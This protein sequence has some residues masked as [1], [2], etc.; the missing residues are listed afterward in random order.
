MASQTLTPARTDEPDGT[1]SPLTSGLVDLDGR[2]FYRIA[3]YDEMPPFFMTL[4][5]ASDLWLFI[6]STGGVTA[7]REEADRALFPYATDDKVSA[8]AGRTG[9]LT[10]LR[11]GTPD[12]VRFWQPFA[13]RRPGDP[14]VERHLYKDHLGTTLVFEETRPDVGLRIRVTWRTSARYGIVREV[15]LA[16]ATDR[17]VD[18]DVLDGF[19]D[20]LPPGVTVQTQS[21]FSRLLDAYKRAEVDAA[22]G[23]GLVYL[24]S[25]LTDKSD[26]S[27][28]LAATVA[29]QVGLDDVEHLLSARQVGAFAAGRPITPEDEVR[30]EK[31]AYLVRTRV[32]LAP[33]E[34]RRWSV[35]ADV[36]Q[37]AAD[38]VRLQ[39]ELA[40]RTAAAAALAA[41]VETT[42]TELD[43]LVGTADAAQ[44]TGDEL[45]AAHHRA[46]VLF[47]V[48]RGGVLVDGY[49][50]H[51]DDL[52]AFVAQ[53]SPRTAARQADWLAALPATDLLDAL[54]ERADATGDPDLL[55]LVREYLPLTFS[56]RHGDPSRPWN[57][58]KIALT[59][60]QGRTRVDFQGNWRD[61]FQN[62]EA[63]AWSFPEY[64]ESMVA[65][66]LDATTADGY[67]PYR[68]SRSGID[69]EV[70]EPSNPWANIGYWSDH[71]IIYLVKLLEASR[72]FHPGRLDALVDRPLFTHADVPYRIASYEQ[73]LVEPIDTIAFDTDA[74]ERVL[75]RVETEG[76]DGRLVHGADGDLVRVSLGEK[77]LLLLL[78][79]TVN[80][81]PDGGIWMNTQRP[82]W[83]DANNA[84]V[85]K[86]LSVVT[87]A[88]LRRGLALARELL[89]DDLTVTAELADLLADV[90]EALRAHAA[91]VEDGFDDTSRRAVM[92]ALG[93]AGTAYRTRVYAGFGGARTTVALADVQ[94]FLDLAQRYVD[95]A[96]HANRRPDGLF[97]A[98]NLLDLRD[99]RA[100]IGRLQEMLEGQVAVLSS[101]VLTP[102]EALDLV[103]ALRRSALYREDQ[104]S[105]QLYP[106]RELPTFLQRNRITAEQVATAP[107]VEALVAAGD[108]SLVLRDVRGE[109]RF[110]PGLHNARDV[111]AALDALPGRVPG[112]SADDLAAGR[113]GVLDV[114]EQVFRHAEFTGR[115]GSF[116]AYEGLGSIYWHMVSKLLLAVQENHERAVVEGADPAV[117]QG[118]ADAYEDVRLGLGYC[119]TPEVYGAFPVDPYSHTPAGR[120]ARQPGMTG[121]V[122]EEVLTRL[123]ELGLRVEDGRVLVRPV[124]LR[125]EEW[126]TAP[127]TFTYRD[128]AQ[129]EQSLPLDAGQLAFTFC[130]V[131]VVYRRGSAVR[132][133][134]HLADGSQVEGA[135]GVLDAAVSEQVFRRTGDVVRIDVEVPAR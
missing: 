101:G 24:N 77:L 99:G 100:R 107:L 13:D 51:T 3:S 11:V 69:W 89:A 41:D 76:A 37:S 94:G 73:T 15:E 39:T 66:F 20:L 55:R 67:N 104:H 29:W 95:A 35:V 28:S 131:P 111:E 21:E 34:V 135:D 27:E 14:D 128:V 22:T 121:Q 82:E 18:A 127:A 70:P 12:G 61:I 118:L 96:L 81:V 88:Y 108:T 48:M 115:S 26:P 7:G 87:L 58:F 116:F 56:R 83:N 126:T 1:S 45:A 46:N 79:K 91:R 9:G 10:L 72:R 62:W 120:G 125:Q 6:S 30:G 4:V 92:D 33:G 43:R 124:L 123:G 40:D 71:Q 38:V 93:A 44:L 16:S 112:L 113:Q 17:A 49:T 63:L 132:V 64:V 109:H 5:G 97:H 110:A 134:A 42:R 52:R 117:V 25:T 32:T 68:I 86:G 57:K 133:V 102:G 98:Y 23:L 85:G 53:R 74:E 19:V 103:Q 47:N 130:Q 119:K 84:L 36:D 60:A 105:Y 8:G 54:V 114:F 31:G 59:D 65:V 129:A 78:A 80:I 90:H 75:R 106:D 122:K 50:V 2:R